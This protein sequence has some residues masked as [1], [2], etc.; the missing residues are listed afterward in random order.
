MYV[1]TGL[2]VVSTD[3]PVSPCAT[4]WAWSI[5]T[6]WQWPKSLI[7]GDSYSNPPAPPVVRSTLPD[8]SP[9]PAVPE[10]GAA[11][12]DTIQAITDQQIRDMQTGNQDFFE[13]LDPKVNPPAGV[14]WWVWG[15]VGLAV[16]G[17]VALG[18]GSPRRYGR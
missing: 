1:R 2:G 5:P 14:P 8:G 6:C 17:V 4:R 11:A 10:S 15:G 18:G 13:E 16:F 9:I 7:Y 3:V 12:Q